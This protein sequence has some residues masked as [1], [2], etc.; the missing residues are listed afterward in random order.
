M[1]SGYLKKDDDVNGCSSQVKNLDGKCKKSPA[2]P[3]IHACDATKVIRSLL[4][5][6]RKANRKDVVFPCLKF[7]LSSRSK[8]FRTS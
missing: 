8:I 5:S 1:N 3:D 6:Y 2:R 7:F 4:M